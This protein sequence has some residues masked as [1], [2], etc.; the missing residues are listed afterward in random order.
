MK[1]FTLIALFAL[2]FG[3][4]SKAQA[5][6]SCHVYVSPTCFSGPLFLQGYRVGTYVPATNLSFHRSASACTAAVKALV[7]YCRGSDSYS[8]VWSMFVV[9]GKAITGGVGQGGTNKTY[10]WIPNGQGSY[11]YFPF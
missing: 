2:T 10:I 1:L 9:N 6:Q 4:Q 5:G 8:Q 3:L 7:P 11:N